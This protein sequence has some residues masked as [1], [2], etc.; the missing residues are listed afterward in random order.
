MLRLWKRLKALLF[1]SPAGSAPAPRSRRRR[2]SRRKRP[3]LV[4]LRRRLQRERR[5]TQPTTCESPPYRFA[6]QQLNLRTGEP[7]GYFDLSQ[8]GR[9]EQLERWGLPLFFTPD[10]LADWLGLHVGRVA[11][12]A[13][14]V[15][16]H[17]SVPLEKRCHYGHRFLRKRNGDW[18]LIEAPKPVLK[19]VQRKIHSEIL[20]RVPIHPNAHGFARGRSIVSNARPHVGQQ[21][22]LKLDLANFYT[23]IGYPRVV[24][25]FRSIGY[26]REAAIWLARLTTSRVPHN[27]K[28]PKG[29]KCNLYYYRQRHLP[30]GAP[31]SPALAN[32][33]AY[34]LDVRLSGMARAFGAKY[35]RYADD[36]TFS[37]DRRWERSL[38][39]FIPLV[40][41]II[42]S[43]RFFVQH[44]KR[45]VVRRSRRQVVTGVVVNERTGVC[46]P[47][48][49]RLKA[50]LHNCIRHGPS[51][52]NRSNVP[53]F[54]S[55]L[56]GRIAHVCQLDAAKGARLRQ[57]FEQI[58]WSR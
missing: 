44:E 51:T 22:I 14:R 12:L 48:Y 55:H 30:Q 19:E 36:L 56:S 28:V 18:R 2:R 4:P 34:S 3:R 9:P 17:R 27:L 54:R 47:D 31:T 15:T 46:R 16:W 41:Q 43:E 6:R 5:W 58:D 52:Q 26:S 32:L 37:G 49:D 24:A 7:T 13:D 29:G 38:S 57:W 35:T 10:E 33:S 1:G 50:I 39:T 8:D 53:D 45:Q 21:V 42:Q 25:I 23:T 40:Q 11:W 20:R